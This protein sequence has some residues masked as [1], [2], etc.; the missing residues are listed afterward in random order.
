MLA[1]AV[2]EDVPAGLG[3]G[4]A[5]EMGAADTATADGEDDAELRMFALQ[6]HEGGDAAGGT[7][8]IGLGVGIIVAELFANVSRGRRGPMDWNLP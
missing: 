1:C 5:G 4:G 8:D 3:A 2:R 6:G 7:V